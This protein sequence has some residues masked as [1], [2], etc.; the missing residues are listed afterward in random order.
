M[1]VHSIQC[2]KSLP[3]CRKRVSFIFIKVL[4]KQLSVTFVYSFSSP[5]GSDSVSSIPKNEIFEFL[6]SRMPLFLRVSFYS[7][8]R[9]HEPQLWAWASSTW[10]LFI[11]RDCIFYVE[12]IAPN[13]NTRGSGH[14]SVSYAETFDLAQILN[15]RVYTFILEIVL[16]KDPNK[17]IIEGFLE[18]L[19][20]LFKESNKH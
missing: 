18:L 3:F 10:L 11:R 4:L 19:Y 8:L 17:E 2:T 6:A 1:I 7:L 5:I 13:Q 15:T 14:L 9:Y 12:Q 20:E 16:H